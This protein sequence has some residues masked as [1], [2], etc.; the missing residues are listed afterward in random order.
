MKCNNFDFKTYDFV[1]TRF[2]E[3]N[4]YYI[5]IQ[6]VPNKRQGFLEKTGLF[7]KLFWILK[8]VIHPVFPKNPKQFWNIDGTVTFLN[9]VNIQLIFR[10]QKQ[11]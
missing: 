8:L 1:T 3:Y 7:P 9:N 4:I 5:I 11:F 2:E 10:I 6:D